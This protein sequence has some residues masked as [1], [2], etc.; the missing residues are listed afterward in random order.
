MLNYSHRNGLPSNSLPGDLFSDSPTGV[1]VTAVHLKLEGTRVPKSLVFTPPAIS[2]LGLSG[3]CRL[4]V[5]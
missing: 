4:R 2:M 1:F 3:L 5:Q